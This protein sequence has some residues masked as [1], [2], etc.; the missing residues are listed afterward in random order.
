MKTTFLIIGTFLVFMTN[1]SGQNVGSIGRD[2]DF[3]PIAV[4]LQNPENAADYST[5]GINMFVGLWGGPDQKKLDLLRKAN[6]KVICD[7]NTYGLSHL[8][9]EIIYG[10]MHGDEPDNAQRSKTTKD[11]DPCVDPAI[12][13]NSYNDIKKNDPSRPVYINLGQG[14]SY[15]DYIGRG[16]CRGDINKYK[17]SAN[18]YLKGCDIAS[19]DIYPVNSRY[20]EIKNKLWYVPKGID[21]LFSWSNNSKPVWCWIECTQISE[22]SPRKPTTAEVKAEVW[23]ALIHGAN[24][25]GYFCHSFLT[26]TD[27]AALLHDITM[28]KAVKII[29]TQ[30]ISLA[31]VLNSPDYKGY[32]TVS[33]TNTFVPVDIMT[34]KLKKEKYIFAVGMRCGFTTATFSVMSGTSVE[35]LGEGRIINISDGQFSDEFSPYGVHLYKIRE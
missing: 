5:N 23:M 7:Q 25:I 10:W 14:V 24:G 26:P 35:V 21:S 6:I 27:D 22:R 11:Y 32:A 20:E 9:D 30:L 29:N 12:I 34:K 18:G 16:V 15:I 2:P 8:D 19:F 31:P 33:S 4:W 1:I 17:V 28:I 3:F 13:I